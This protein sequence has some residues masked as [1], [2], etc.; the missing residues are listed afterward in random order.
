[1]SPISAVLAV[2]VTALGSA[3]QGAVGFGLGPLGAPLLLLIDPRLVPGP[4]LLAALVL[5]LLMARRE[6]HGV[7][8]RDLGWSIPGRVAGTVAAVLFLGAIAP[9]RLA[10]VVGALILVAVGLSATGL[11]LALTPSSLLGAGAV[12]GFLATLTSIGGPPMG[13]LY[14]SERGDVVRGTLSA[15]FVVGIAFSVA[16]LWVAG[17][18]G[19]T[20]IRLSILLLPGVVVGYALSGPAAR[21]LDRGWLRPAILAT[22]AIA[23]VLVVVKYL[24]R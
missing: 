2:L 6:W 5:T 16:G 1:M 3:L 12:S 13:L 21:L 4:L 11:R 8:F 7:R 24:V 17:R 9:D 22:S 19:M 15:F 14:Q 20:E 10:A 23:A 18:F